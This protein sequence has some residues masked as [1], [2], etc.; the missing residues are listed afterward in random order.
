MAHGFIEPPK[1]VVV[2]GVAYRAQVRRDE[3]TGRGYLE[4]FCPT[5]GDM[6]AMF[7]HNGVEDE[8]RMVMVRDLP[9]AAVQ[10]FA[11]GAEQ[12]TEKLPLFQRDLCPVC[13]RGKAA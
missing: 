7:V 8:A 9:A 1:D 12:L 11:R 5:T 4:V 13:N 10:R 3:G 2:D 6:L